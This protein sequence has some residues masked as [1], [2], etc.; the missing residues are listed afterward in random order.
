[1]TNPDYSQHFNGNQFFNNL[2][3][4][5]MRLGRDAMLLG[6]QLYY[7]AKDASTPAWAKGV[8]YSALGYFILPIDM[9]PDMLPGIGL[10]D[11]ILVMISA[12]GTVA[13]HV[14]QAHKRQAEE[15]LNARFG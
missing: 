1:M 6:L 14:T 12:L 4:Q 5:A 7:A 13:A 10:S 9:V 2:V 15:W 8:I 11:D 3:G